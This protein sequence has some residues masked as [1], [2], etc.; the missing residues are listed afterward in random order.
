MRFFLVT[1]VFELILLS[2]IIVSCQVWTIRP[3]LI[4]TQHN[5]TSTLRV[6][7]CWYSLND[8]ITTIFVYKSDIYLLTLVRISLVL[9]SL[10]STGRKHS[11]LTA[12]KHCIVWISNIV[13]ID[14]RLFLCYLSCHKC[15]LEKTFR[16]N[17]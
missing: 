2:S 10:K 11:I 5:D 17:I 16:V 8:I 1:F 15:L 14:L 9:S 13:Y 7:D 3:G 6:V 4:C 12:D